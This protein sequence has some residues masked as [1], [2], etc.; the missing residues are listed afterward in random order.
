LVIR[1]CYYHQEELR[2]E[3]SGELNDVESSATMK[4]SEISA[5]GNE[6]ATSDDGRP[7]IAVDDEL[8]RAKEH[9]ERVDVKDRD[10]HRDLAIQHTPAEVMDCVTPCSPA[11]G[12]QP[13]TTDPNDLARTTKHKLA[14]SSKRQRSALR[15]SK[16]ADL[17]KGIDLFKMPQSAE[18]GNVQPKRKLRT[19]GPTDSVT[20]FCITAY[21]TGFGDDDHDPVRRWA[22][23]LYLLQNA[24]VQLN[25]N[26]QPKH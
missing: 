23:A 7:D 3:E 11:D 2:S 18:S 25:R 1:H 10:E 21:V 9:D 4:A 17:A 16:R 19:E 26:S 22:I 20:G 8:E 5:S 12:A 14:A 13:D 15:E 6:D 24:I